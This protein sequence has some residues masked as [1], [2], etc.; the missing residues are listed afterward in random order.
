MRRRFTIATD[1]AILSQ[2]GLAMHHAPT[3]TDKE[4]N[5]FK[6]I[7]T[8]LAGLT[9]LLITTA[10]G[11]A[12]PVKIGF[13]HSKTG[14]FAAAATSQLQSYE[15]WR[16]QLNAVGGLDIAGTRRKIEFIHYDDQSNSG[17]AVQIYEKLITDDKVDLLLAPW[18]TSLHFAIVGVISRY[19]FPV[20][21]NTA[22]SV[23]LRDLKAG[24]IWF[25]TS[26]FPDRQSVELAKLL[27]K[28]GVTSAALI[29]NQLPYTQENKKFV[30][31]ALK[32]AGI[33]LLVNEDYP[34]NIKDM[35]A[36]LTKVK[37]A[38]PQAVL[39]YTY[40]GD[41]V[42]YVKG[43]REVG[44]NAA[45]Q[46]VLLGPQYDFFAKIFGPT[47]NGLVTM[48]HWT[49]L[50]KD[51]PTAKVFFDDFKA[52]WKTNAD[53]LDAP[54]AYMSVQILQ[55]A[56][57]KAGLDKNKLRQVISSTTFKSINGPVRF[58]GVENIA[59]PTMI[60]QIQNGQQHIVWPPDQAT[61]K[62]IAKPAWK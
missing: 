25:P 3:K 33:K 7:V 37:K 6:R 2:K 16:E 30:V 27:K 23:Q 15:L 40:P 55:Q 60:S 24:N 35:T 57:A 22:A 56:V 43:A 47:R 21:G 12:D 10:V 59:L 11:A 19:K 20:V 48:G 17:K 38:K 9:A 44:L 4:V 51:W 58:K 8:T 26:L 36:L 46:V 53:Y 13:S 42:L 28:Q 41:A 5:M 54:L 18:G 62:I 32:E 50:R 61:S 52:R 45:T 34:P 39:A 49:P 29:T 31:P 14:I 1:F